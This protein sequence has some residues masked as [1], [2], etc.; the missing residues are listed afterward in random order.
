MVLVLDAILYLFL[1][2]LQLLK[3]K[4]NV[5]FLTSLPFPDYS[6]ANVTLGIKFKLFYFSGMPQ[7]Q[8]FERLT[9]CVC[10]CIRKLVLNLLCSDSVWK[11]TS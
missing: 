2:L 8:R 5:A 9:K 6:A 1:S 4:T 3:C 10:A 11:K 7:T